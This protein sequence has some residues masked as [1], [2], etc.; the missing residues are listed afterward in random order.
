MFHLQIVHI[1]WER[2]QITPVVV[3]DESTMCS[4]PRHAHSLFCAPSRTVLVVASSVAGN[5]NSC[6]S[7]LRGS[8]TDQ[9]DPLDRPCYFFQHR[10]MMQIRENVWYVICTDLSV[11]QVVLGMSSALRWKSWPLIDVFV[12]QVLSP[13]PSFC[14]P[15][16]LHVQLTTW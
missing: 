8:C 2:V 14:T 7:L 12:V 3:P 4:Q 11:R 9:S 1:T 15:S 6:R 10:E 5:T 16:H 13:P